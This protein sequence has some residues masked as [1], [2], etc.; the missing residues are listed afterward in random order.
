[1]TEFSKR[2]S[3]IDKPTV[4]ITGDSDEIVLEEI[5]SKGARAR[6]QRIRTRLD[7][8]ARPQA[9][10]HRDRHRSL[11][12]WSKISGQARDLQA[13]AVLQSRVSRNGVE[14]EGQAPSLQAGQ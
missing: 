7:Q 2:Y 10:L 1:M 11:R 9:G 5:H 6:Y 8:G 14:P 4:I 12:H 3:E 13:M